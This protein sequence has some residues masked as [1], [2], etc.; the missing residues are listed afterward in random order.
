LL[1]DTR[2]CLVAVE[3][4]RSDLRCNVS[5]ESHLLSQ[6]VKV[7]QFYNLSDLVSTGNIAVSTRQRIHN[8]NPLAKEFHHDVYRIKLWMKKGGLCGA[9]GTVPLWY[10]SSGII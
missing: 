2:M 3:F 6:K 1:Y 4:L 9:S 10:D 5:H 8:N 7:R